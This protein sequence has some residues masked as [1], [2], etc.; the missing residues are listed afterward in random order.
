MFK[1]INIPD[2]WDEVTIRQFQELTSLE[3]KDF[4]KT[5]D[6]ISILTNED[7]ETIRQFDVPTLT[8]ILSNLIWTNTMPDDAKYKPLLFYK[9]KEFGII[10]RLSDL[11]VGEWI[12]LEN[13][14][15]SPIDNIHFIMSILY[16]PLITAFND[17]DRLI[18]KYDSDVM[19]RQAE[20]F[21]DNIK[22]TDV[23]GALIFFSL[24]A[25][26]CMNV[27]A[28][29]LEEDHQLISKMKLE[30]SPMKTEK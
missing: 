4:E 8:E 18:E 1:T 13:Y 21:L 9:E 15:E 29:Y 28:D 19:I 11:T 24:I 26:E 6:I 7:P 20:E 25:K 23:Y 2:S 17:R 22:I 10:S 12:D 3:T 5:L 16:R 27:I 30:E 14:L